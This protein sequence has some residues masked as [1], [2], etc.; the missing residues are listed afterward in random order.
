MPFRAFPVDGWPLPDHYGIGPWGQH[1]NI[2]AALARAVVIAL[3]VAATGATAVQAAVCSVPSGSYPTIQSAVD[4]G[5]CTEIVLAAQVFYE[6]PVI[7]RDLIL[8]GVSSTTT[9][10]EGQVEVQGGSCE[11]RQLKVDASSATLAGHYNEALWV[12]SGAEVSGSDLVVINAS[13]LF[14]D[15]FE[16]GDTS[17]WSAAVP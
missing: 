12:H 10:I 13:V 6:S 1:M 3:V 16:S 17:A 7:G 5:D 9:I 11:V 14:A 8:R 4:D 15:G 2:F